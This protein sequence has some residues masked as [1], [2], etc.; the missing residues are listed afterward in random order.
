MAL[1]IRTTP[2]KYVLDSDKDKPLDLQTTYY[3][4]QKTVADV[5]EVAVGYREALIEGRRGKSSFSSSKLSSADINQ[6]ITLVIKVE[7]YFVPVDAPAVMSFDPVAH[8]KKLCDSGNPNVIK[9]SYPDGGEQVECYKVISTEDKTDLKYLAV[10]LET[11]Q[12]E[13]IFQVC[14][15]LSSLSNVEK[16]D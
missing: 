2:F 12:R 9:A 10:C 8:F 7:N 5:N 13:E 11:K 6:F 3:L 15:D 16:K 4:R 1:G 14:E